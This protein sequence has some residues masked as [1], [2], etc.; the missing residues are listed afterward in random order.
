MTVIIE[1]VEPAIL[2]QWMAEG[3]AHV[4]DV[5]EPPERAVEVI[6]GTLAAPLSQ[7]DGYGLTTP[8]GKK[9]VIHCQSGVRCGM[10]AERLEA[11]GFE[12][13]IYRLRGGLL[14]W[15]EAGLPTQAGDG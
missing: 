7:F 15:K 11:G 1:M 10:A 3:S 2:Q 8:S 14:A 5:R 4:I 13:E 9:L 12:G 6:A